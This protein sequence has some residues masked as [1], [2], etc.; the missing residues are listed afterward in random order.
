M[1]TKEHS[2]RAIAEMIAARIDR[3][4]HL[5]ARVLRVAADGKVSTVGA[6]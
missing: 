5:D 6:S 2:P 4:P 3:E 1:N